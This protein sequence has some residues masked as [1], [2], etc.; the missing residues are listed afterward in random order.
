MYQNVIRR[1]MR[2]AVIAVAALALGA[3]VVGADTVI[4]N[5]PS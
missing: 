1:Q 2:A 4:A 5:A 3:T